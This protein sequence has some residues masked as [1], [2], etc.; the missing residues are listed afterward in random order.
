MCPWKLVWRQASARP[1]THPQSQQAC[2]MVNKHFITLTALNPPQMVMLFFCSAAQVTLSTAVRHRTS[3]RSPRGA[4]RL[5]RHAASPSASKLAC[6]K[7]VSAIG[8]Q[9]LCHRTLFSFV[10]IFPEMGNA[11]SLFSPH[12]TPV[13]LVFSQ[14]RSSPRQSERRTAKVQETPRSG[15]RHIP[16]C[17]STTDKGEW[18]RWES[19]SCCGLSF[20]AQYSRIWCLKSQTQRSLMSPGSFMEEEDLKSSRVAF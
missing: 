18:K 3:A 14:R 1:P 7:R 15:E 20:T 5:A 11:W 19:S 9:R 13:V 6:W 10:L 2:W 17:P 12:L 16:E 4:G 8:V